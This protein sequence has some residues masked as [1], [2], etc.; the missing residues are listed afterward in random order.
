MQYG[1]FPMP[2]APRPRLNAPCHSEQIDLNRLFRPFRSRKTGIL[3]KAQ[4]P[5]QNRSFDS[6]CTAGLDQDD[7]FA[8]VFPVSTQ[9]PGLRA[10]V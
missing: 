4:E 5:G 2:Q 1:F 9:Y 8:N 7:T 10:K 3:I 6:S